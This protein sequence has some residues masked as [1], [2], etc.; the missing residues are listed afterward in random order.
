V[1]DQVGLVNDRPE[2]RLLL[3]PSPPA[4]HAFEESVLAL[5]PDIDTSAQIVFGGLVLVDDRSSVVA[6]R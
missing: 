1:V 6:R 4:G 5:H 2:Q 3:L